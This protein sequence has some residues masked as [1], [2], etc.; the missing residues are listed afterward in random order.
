MK[1]ILAILLIF[2]SS[3]AWAATQ[4]AL[5]SGDGVVTGSGWSVFPSSPTT[6]FDKMDDPVVSPDGDSSYIQNS[7]NA[8]SA[9][10]TYSAFT[11]PAGSTITDVTVHYNA[12]YTGATPHTA[13]AIYVNSVEYNGSLITPSAT[14]ADYSDTWSTNPSTSAAWTVADVNGTGAHPL[15]Q[16]GVYGENSKGKRWT[17]VYMVVTYTPPVSTVKGASLLM[18]LQ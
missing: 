3:S 14:Y 5:P 10:F 2:I 17:Q 13:S 7:N 1:T 15:T 16:F 4:T 6:K 8:V 12:E 18:L 9:L 11:V